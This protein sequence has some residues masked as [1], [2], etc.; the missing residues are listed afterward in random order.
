MAL[1]EYCDILW[2]KIHDLHDIALK[3]DRFSNLYELKVII[4]KP[5]DAAYTFYLDPTKKFIPVKKE[6][7]ENDTLIKH[8]NC[9]QF[10]NVNNVWI[11]YSYSC[12]E[13]KERRKQYYEVEEASANIDIEDSLFDF[14]FPPDAIVIDEIADIKNKFKM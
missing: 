12:T 2:K 14:D 3:Y 7:T 10:Q 5:I 8:I 11:P 9:D 13:F 4:Q 1:W 6:I